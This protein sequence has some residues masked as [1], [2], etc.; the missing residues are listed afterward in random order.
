CCQSPGGPGWGNQIHSLSEEGALRYLTI[1]SPEDCC[2]YCVSS[3]RCLQW[4]FLTGADGVNACRTLNVDDAIKICNLPLTPNI[5]LMTV[6]NGGI[7]RCKG[8][9][10]A[11][12]F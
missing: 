6:T 2:K 9:C 5:G 1:N 11:E 8:G 12:V 4:L 7:I 3:P 10:M